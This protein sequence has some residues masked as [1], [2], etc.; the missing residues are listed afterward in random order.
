MTAAPARLQ[1]VQAALPPPPV[2]NDL[3]LD[4]P[5]KGLQ[6]H[7]QAPGFGNEL[8]DAGHSQHPQ[9]GQEREV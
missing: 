9:Q 2:H 7:T 8:E 1:R 5:N 3:G 6:H 4:S